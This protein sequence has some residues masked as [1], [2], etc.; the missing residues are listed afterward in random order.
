MTKKEEIEQMNVLN[1]AFLGDALFTSY[2]R[3]VLVKKR[4]QKIDVLN[5]LSSKI[6]CAKNQAVLLDNFKDWLNDDEH[7]TIMR[8]RNAKKNSVAKN[9]LPEE[10]NKSTQFEALLGYLYLSEQTERLNMIL[11][12]IGKEIL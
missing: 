12:K 1:L 2:V 10:Y 11:D 4:D 5:K 6:V 7:A 9:C 8:A 3:E